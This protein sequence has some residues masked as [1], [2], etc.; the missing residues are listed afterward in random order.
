MRRTRPAAPGQLLARLLPLLAIAAC[1]RGGELPADRP[2][3]VDS[4]VLER[5][6]CYGSCPAYR[7]RI[8]ADGELT[9]ASRN[10]GDTAG[11][12][13]DSIAPARVAWLAREVERLGFFSL[14]PVIADDSTLCPLRATDHPTATV[15]VFREDSTHEV[16]DYHGCYV[17]HDLTIAP[18]VRELRQLETEI[19]S[20]AG[21]DRW[22]SAPARR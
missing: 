19:D 7:L 18:P 9:F 8:R 5:T 20:V 13:T 12:K 14:P 6:L 16:V 3:T 1:H 17:S 4:L 10:P 22:A 2:V 15:T 21:V 11:A